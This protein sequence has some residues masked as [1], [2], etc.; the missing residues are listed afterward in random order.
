MLDKVSDQGDV[1]FFLPADVVAVLGEPGEES[2]PG[3]T[4]I[5]DVA[6]TAPDE[7]NTVLGTGATMFLCGE[8]VVVVL[9]VDPGLVLK[10][11]PVSSGP[12]VRQWAELGP[13][14]DV[15]EIVIFTIGCYYAVVA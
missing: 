8:H 3:L 15:L 2:V 6:G 5:L 9:I 10:E 4:H 1:C 13:N 11:L 7:V 14:Q 12:G